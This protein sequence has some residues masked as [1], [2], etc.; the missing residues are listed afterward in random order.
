[1]EKSYEAIYEEGEMLCS[2]L[3][4]IYRAFFE[5]RSCINDEGRKQDGRK[6][7]RKEGGKEGNSA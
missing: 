3:L 7:G 5:R 4:P 6:E 1:M 2:A